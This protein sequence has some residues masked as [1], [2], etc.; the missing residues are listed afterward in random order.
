MIHT[1]GI[2]DSEWPSLLEIGILICNEKSKADKMQGRYC[3][4][5]V[6]KNKENTVQFCSVFLP[7]YREPC[8]AESY[9]MA[10]FPPRPQLSAWNDVIDLGRVRRNGFSLS[11]R[12]SILWNGCLCLRDEVNTDHEQNV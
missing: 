4:E 9:L 5:S 8:I 12:S 2:A 7:S 1:P 3:V 6:S 11:I 10:A